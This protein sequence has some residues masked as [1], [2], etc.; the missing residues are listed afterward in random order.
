MEEVKNSIQWVINAWDVPAH[1]MGPSLDLWMQKGLRSF[2]TFVPWQGFENDISRVFQRFLQHAY[3]R[4]L[5]VDIVVTPELGMSYPLEGIPK[6]LISNS[7]NHARSKR[8]GVLTALTPPVAHPLP[9]WFSP[10]MQ[11]RYFSFLHRFQSHLQDF[12]E[13]NAGAAE[14]LRVLVGGSYFKYYRSAVSSAYEEFG[15]EAGDYSAAASNEFRR[16]LDERFSQDSKKRLKQQE[17]GQYRAFHRYAE[18]VFR[19]KVQQVLSKKNLGVPVEQIEL[20]TP[21]LDPAMQLDQFFSVSMGKSIDGFKYSRYLSKATG[22]Y[23]SWNGKEAAPV[24]FWTQNQDCGQNTMSKKQNLLLQAWASVVPRG[25]KVWMSPQ[26]WYSFSEGFRTKLEGLSTAQQENK[27]K[28]Q[29]IVYVLTPHFWSTHR[30]IH[31]I[32]E[33]LQSLGWKVG[34]RFVDRLDAIKEKG[35]SVLILVDPDIEFTEG[36]TSDLMSRMRRSKSVWFMSESSLLDPSLAT[37]PHAIHLDQ[38]IPC[39]ILPMNEGKWVVYC[40]QDSMQA[41]R[42]LM[43]Q[44]INL[45]G[46]SG[47]V[48]S[49]SKEAQHV[50]LTTQNP[51]EILHFVFNTSDTVKTFE[52]KFVKQQK[53][54]EWV[55]SQ[56]NLDVPAQGVMTFVSESWSDRTRSSTIENPL[57][58]GTHQRLESI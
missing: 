24:L 43:H 14:H 44:M 18:E 48:Q 6:D 41:L 51:S 4:R 38:G 32:L 49:I 34:V 7:H 42:T 46:E 53:V 58:N 17:P 36:Q 22:R 1:Q 21:E 9:T 33:Q 27:W 12:C 26:D 37:A 55:G 47:T 28:A 31:L 56:M 54:G 2:I 13:S 52:V 11:K 30:W 25:G 29:D 8:H 5:S 15:T 45:V 3:E 35:R 39:R 19:T 40:M 20:F 10:E 16:Y 57:I 23:G 50:E